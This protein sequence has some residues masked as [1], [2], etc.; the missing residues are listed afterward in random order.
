MTLLL[1]DVKVLLGPR[2]TDIDINSVLLVAFILL[3]AYD[4][5]HRLLC[6]TSLVPSCHGR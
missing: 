1:V 2:K 3:A 5:A 4:E 6:F